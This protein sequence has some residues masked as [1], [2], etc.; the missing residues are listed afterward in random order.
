MDSDLEI[1]QAVPQ[2]DVER[3]GELVQRYQLAAWKLAFSFVGNMEEAKDVSQN[4]FVK[5]YRHLHR[6]R[7]GAKFSTWL[8]RILANECKDS[9]RRKVRQPEMV[10][11][12]AESEA[13]LDGEG[14][15]FEPADPGANP[16]HAAANREMAGRLSQAIRRLPMKQRSAFLLHHVNGL[17]LAEVSQVMGCRVGTVKAHLFRASESLRVGLGPF[18]TVEDF[19]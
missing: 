19:R 2:G 1:I 4:G 16:R 6:F 8:Y 3:Y 12:A 17:P 18:L 13:S 9:L 10:P 5:A 15:L 14:P 7:A 11:M